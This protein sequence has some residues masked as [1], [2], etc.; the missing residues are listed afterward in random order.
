MGTV[1]EFFIETLVVAGLAESIS[2][3]VK[4]SR[5]NPKSMCGQHGQIQEKATRQSTANPSVGRGKGNQN[6]YWNPQLQR[7]PKGVARGHPDPSPRVPQ[8]LH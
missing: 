7:A 2:E 5:S 4:P 1:K 6:E 8:G 3:Y